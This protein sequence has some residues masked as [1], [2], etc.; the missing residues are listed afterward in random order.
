[1]FSKELALQIFDSKYS[2]KVEH[3]CKL[4]LIVEV[5]TLLSESYSCKDVW[6]ARYD[7]PI[8]KQV[9][10]GQLFKSAY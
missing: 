5:R 6:K 9:Q 7:T 3:C 4:L 8:F 10:P 1:M 2:P